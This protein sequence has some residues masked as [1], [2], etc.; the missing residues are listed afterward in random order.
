MCGPS[1]ATIAA[2]SAFRSDT[3]SPPWRLCYQIRWSPVNLN[4]PPGD[5]PT[6]SD[7]RLTSLYRGVLAGERRSLARSITLVESTRRGDRERAIELIDALLPHTGDATRLAISGTP[8]VGKSTF[9]ETVGLAAC[10]QGRRVAVLSVDPSSART[11][12]S[13]LGDK[14]RM[15]EL[16]RRDDAFIR[17]SPSGGVLGGVGQ[18]TR[19]A[20]LICEAAGFDLVIVETVGVGQSETTAADL[21]DL[22]LLLLAPGGGDDLQ[23]IKRGIMELADIVAINKADGA[24][25]DLA[26]HT[27]AD[28]RAALHLVRPKYPNMETEV[29]ACSALTGDGIEEL[30]QLIDARARALADSGHRAALRQEQAVTALHADLLYEL[31]ARLLRDPDVA[32]RL[33]ELELAVR[34]GHRSPGSAAAEVLDRSS[35][36]QTSRTIG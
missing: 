19:E 29:V 5:K 3:S 10:R 27:V 15:P 9:I 31:R 4:Q 12:G 17:P 35:G 13:I 2:C 23:G 28:H 21:T 14:T 30:L 6:L 33:G 24:L 36:Q 16:T 34:Q 20:L 18:R 32:D 7:E 22:F 25:V 8:G 11:G 1:A 26:R